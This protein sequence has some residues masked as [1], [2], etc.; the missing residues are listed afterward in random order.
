MYVCVDKFA[1]NSNHI[2]SAIFQCLQ[3]FP[4][5]ALKRIILTASGGAFRDWPVEK[6]K[7]VRVADALKHPNWAMG[8]LN[9]IRLLLFFSQ[10]IIHIYTNDSS[11]V[12]IFKNMCIPHILTC[13]RF[14]DV[15]YLVCRVIM[16]LPFSNTYI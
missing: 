3:G 16:I 8:K 9:S 2:I 1:V 14:Q 13:I 5:G 4:P 7:E 15:S 11:N 10:Y 6:L 12:H